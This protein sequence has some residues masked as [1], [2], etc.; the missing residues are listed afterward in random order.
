MGKMVA[1]REE[2]DGSIRNLTG[3][4]MGG[5]RI[6]LEVK[7][8]H[9]SIVMILR[10]HVLLKFITRSNMVTSCILGRSYP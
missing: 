2:Y 1:R 3:N 5:D 4:K 6:G 10:R 8:G 9:G 7:K